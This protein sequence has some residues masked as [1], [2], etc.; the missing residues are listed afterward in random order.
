MDVRSSM[1]L[2]GCSCP[3]PEAILQRNG[4]CF[5]AKVQVRR[6]AMTDLTFEEHIAN[7]CQ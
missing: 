3:L 5:A 7:G 2:R 6:L 1:S 4:D